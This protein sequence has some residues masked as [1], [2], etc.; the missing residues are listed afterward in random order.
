MIMKDKI[1]FVKTQNLVQS[2]TI[3]LLGAALSCFFIF[4]S[5]GG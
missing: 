5:G 1:V 4:W 2:T 3:L